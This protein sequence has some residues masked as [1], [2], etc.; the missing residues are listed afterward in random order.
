MQG[1]ASVLIILLMIALSAFGLL[2]LYGARSDYRLA[3]KNADWTQKYYTVDTLAQ[4]ETARLDKALRDLSEGVYD[5]SDKVTLTVAARNIITSLGWV[6]PPGGPF[7][8]TKTVSL[9]TMHITVTL[10]LPSP[11]KENASCTVLE[12]LETQD[13]FTYDEGLNIWLGD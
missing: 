4:K 8:V 2:A 13:G 11:V 9:D 5:A 7:T 3:E 10:A 12:W 6:F 1:G